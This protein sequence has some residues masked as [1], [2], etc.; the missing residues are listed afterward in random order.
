MIVKAIPVGSYQSN[1]YMVAPD[2]GGEAMLIDPGA[3]A[4]RLLDEVAPYEV[5]FVVLTHGHVDHIGGVEKVMEALPSAELVAGRDELPLLAN[6]IKNLSSFMGRWV[7][8]KSVTRPVADG[9]ELALG[10]LSFRVLATPGH[11]PGGISL[12]TED[13]GMGRGA[14]FTG[15]ALFAESIGRTDFPG[16]DMD[17][18][19]EAIRTQLLTLPDDT[20]VWSGHGE[21]TTIGEERQHNPFLR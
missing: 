12:Y 5:K 13:D 1:A 20:V 11:T 16:G 8:I 9:D 7:K 3:E 19:L 6:P 17:R 18:L 14:V 10:S 4:A 15:D 21:P 2:A